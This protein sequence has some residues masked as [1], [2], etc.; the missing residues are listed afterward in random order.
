MGVRETAC[1]VPVG[2][3]TLAHTPTPALILPLIF[4]SSAAA[5]CA[6]KG[7]ARFQLRGEGRD[8]LVAKSWVR[9]GRQP[10]PRSLARGE[11]NQN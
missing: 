3:F 10:P 2:N 5:C 8:P 11:G 1:G 4:A 6:E 7:R 9:H